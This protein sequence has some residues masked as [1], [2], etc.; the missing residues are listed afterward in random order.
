ML[1]S[2]PRARGKVGM[3]AKAKFLLLIP[4]VFHR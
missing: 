2:F 4:R 1:L 3:G